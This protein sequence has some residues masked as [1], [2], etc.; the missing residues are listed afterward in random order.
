MR[1]MEEESSIGLMWRRR[2][3]LEPAP[4]SC[5]AWFLRHSKPSRPALGGAEAAQK[6]F[7]SAPSWYRSSAL[8]GMSFGA[9]ASGWPRGGSGFG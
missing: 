8:S 2:A 6:S 3:E 5:S 1:N 4:V 9:S 7:S